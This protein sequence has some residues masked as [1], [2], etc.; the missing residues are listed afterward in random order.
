MNLRRTAALLTALGPA[1][2]AVD[3]GGAAGTAPSPAG[4]PVCTG[5][6][7]V[8][9]GACNAGQA[10]AQFRGQDALPATVAPSA[11]IPARVT[12]T[13]CSGVAWTSDRFALTPAS[14][15]LG[16]PWNL[17]RVPLPVDVPD[18]AEVTLRFE[19]T[20]PSV[21]GAYPLRWAVTREAV[22]TYQEHSPEQ[23]V[24]VLAP[25]DCAEPGPPIRFR[26]QLGPD[27]FL[28]AGRGFRASVTFANCNTE[29]LTRDGGWA[30]TSRVDPDDLWGARRVELPGDVPPGAEVTFPL[31]L[32]APARPGRYPYQWQVTRSGAAVGEPS[33]RAE[34][35]VLEAFDCGE[36]GAPSRFVRQSA[37]PS[38][39]DPGQGFSVSTT[40]ANCSST[41]WDSSHRLDSA[42]DGMARTWGAGPVAL[43]LPVGRGFAVE[44]PFRVRAPDAPGR[45]PYRWAMHGP[46]GALDEPSP[47]TDITVRCV[48][49]CDGRNCGGDGCGGSCG[50]CPGGWSCD[51][52]RC[53]EPNLPMCGALQWWNSYITYEHISSGWRDTDLGVASG[54]PVQLRHTSRLERHGVYGWGYMPEFTDLTTGARFRF[55]HLRPQ[56]QWATDVGRVYPAGSIVGLSGGNT[57]DTGYPRW[58]TGSHLCVQ[59]LWT[60]RAAF[61]SG[62][63]ACR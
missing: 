13:N 8:R 7:C 29:P 30:L 23:V 49:R 35:V 28:A 18:G 51:G 16:V 57:G 62:R 15:E 54:T 11:R 42:L 34:P 40:F 10:S 17:L 20:A 5:A 32:T 56:N 41:T 45:Y 36:G 37:P 31:E 60:Y 48:P 61:P 24:R 59:T 44:V 26:S 47:A 50:S 53:T 33:P 25:A 9:P 55:L 38:T 14:P 63:D 6:A 2:C 43:P 58:S 46:A 21:T 4:D 19:L 27:A 39:V 3:D 22:E 52:G 1:A 12:F